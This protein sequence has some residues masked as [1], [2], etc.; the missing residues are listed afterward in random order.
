VQAVQRT[1]PLPSAFQFS[2]FS[3]IDFAGVR[4]AR[5]SKAKPTCIK[6]S[7]RISA[8]F[9]SRQAHALVPNLIFVI[10]S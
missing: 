1:T 8:K 10:L 3:L 9:I 7:A 4:L 5:L 6:T 2:L